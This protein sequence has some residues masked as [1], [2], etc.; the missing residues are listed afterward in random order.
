MPAGARE[1]PPNLPRRLHAIVGLAAIAAPALHTFTD[2]L[3]WRH[4]GF[5]ELQLWLNLLA[6]LPM[7]F[8]LLGL[9]GVQ[10]P[11]PGADGL[12]GAVLYGAAFAYFTFTTLF[13]LSGRVPDY[14]ALWQR[15]GV[16]YTWFGA[17]M[18]VG[19]LL[20]AWSAWRNGWLPRLAVLLFA[21]GLAV[22]LILALLPAPDILQTI[23]SAMRNVGLMLMGYD[24]LAARHSGR[25]A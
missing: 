18:V 19:G 3:E 4:G 22:N 14:E 12:A 5:T 16:T 15:L 1:L 17:A 20:F 11:R 2:I 25:K 10:S 9:Y 7:P 24:V 23:G 21:S 13:A 8:L 6:F